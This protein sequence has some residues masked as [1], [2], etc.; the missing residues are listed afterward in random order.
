MADRN[1]ELMLRIRA[2]GQDAIATLKR[3][4]QHLESFGKAGSGAWGVAGGALSALGKVGNVVLAPL[5]MAGRAAPLAAAGFAAIAIK[6]LDSRGEI[7][8]LELRMETLTGSAQ[9]ASRVIRETLGGVGV[10]LFS[11]EDLLAARENLMLLGVTGKDAFNAIVNAAAASGRS[12]G[13]VNSVLSNPSARGLRQFGINAS[14]QVD[15][16]MT[17]E[18]TDK[19]GKKMKITT[20]NIDEAR[21]ALVK[22]FQFRFEGS[23]EKL[24]NSWRSA[25]Q[26]MANSV[27]NILQAFGKGLEPAASGLVNSLTVKMQEWI[28]SGAIEGFGKSLGNAMGK[29]L[30]IGEL[31]INNPEALRKTLDDAMR[32]GGEAF[33]TYLV[34]GKDVFISISRMMASAFAEGILA[35]DIPGMKGLRHEMWYSKNKDKFSNIGSDDMQP[36]LYAWKQKSAA[37]QAA[38]VTQGKEDLFKQGLEGL[39]EAFSTAGGSLK[40]SWNK[41]FQHLR[42]PDRPMSDMDEALYKKYGNIWVAGNVTIRADNTEQISKEIRQ[43]AGAPLAAAAGY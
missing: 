38:E 24:A 22:L 33:I 20:Q 21:A 14:G 2:N 26:G 31:L 5:E 11:E 1:M 12:V 36:I 32:F 4:G 3:V 42:K 10:K 30:D 39:P 16:E 29:G 18:T 41:R 13:D 9:E 23:A 35:L 43:S 40:D 17:L 27:D 34:A 19:L 28:G 15:D 25:K 8:Q 7:E 6:A 37:A